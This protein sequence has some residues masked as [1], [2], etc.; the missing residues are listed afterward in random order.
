M[1]HPVTISNDAI[2]LEVWPQFGGKVTSLI[3]KADH[4]DLLFNYPLEIP[5]EPH[6]YDRPYAKGWYAGWD[7][8]F[9]AVAPSRYPG[10]PYEG[11]PVPDH[12]ELWSLPTIATPARDGITTL[13]H[14]LRFGYR[15]TRKLYL[16]GPRV[17]C[18]YTLQNL[19]PFDFRFVWAMHPLMSMAVPVEIDIPRGSAFRHSHDA[20][21]R[22]VDRE[23][24]WPGAGGGEDM[25]RPAGLP[26]N[27]GWKVYSMQPITR[28]LTVR[29]P[30]RSR[31]MTIEYASPDAMPAY[32]GI[33][34]N[35]GGWGSH[36]HFAIEPTT[37]RYDQIDRAVKDHSAGK[38]EGMGQRTWSV[39][40][41]LS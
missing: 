37:G 7:E 23:F 4:F 36:H 1:T 6:H 29:Y 33:W 3:D 8:C 15:L 40:I 26:P 25:S 24:D 9:P 13:W 18:E 14:G 27:R 12:G 35:T 34:I 16:D 22:D 30:S 19:A 41:A 11:I 10:Y 38:V 28:P 32:W 2:E 39:S 20:A 31:D 21:G 5:S 17:V